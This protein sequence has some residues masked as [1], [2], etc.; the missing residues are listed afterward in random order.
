MVDERDENTE[1]D[2]E[3]SASQLTL[4]DSSVSLASAELASA[5]GEAEAA[6]LGATRYVHAAFFGATVLIGFISGKLLLAIW[7]SLADWPRAAEAAPFLLNYD[8]EKRGLVTVL[9][10]AA[11]GLAA[12]I[13]TYRKEGVRRWANEVAA[14]LAKVTWPSKEAVQ[15]GMVVVLITGAIFTAYVA[16]LDRFWGFLTTLV[17]GA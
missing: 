13:Y 10:G 15:N 8:E 3:E 2:S 17:Y 6:E 9:S 5:E 1:T 12:I 11:I 4:S 7:N 14:E 16:L